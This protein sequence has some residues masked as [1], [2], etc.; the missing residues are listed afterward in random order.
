MYRVKPTSIFQ[1]DLKRAEKRGYN[2]S[3]LTEVVALVLFK[4]V[5]Q[6]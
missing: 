3:L 4:A 1:K 2:L 6:L 5:R